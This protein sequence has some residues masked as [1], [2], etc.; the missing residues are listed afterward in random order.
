[1]PLENKLLYEF[2]RFRFDPADRLLSSDGVPVPLAPKAF[3]VLLVL[4][5]NGSRL[6]TKE[7]LMRKVWP[8]SFVEDANLT[9]N[10]SALRR[11]LGE[12]SDGHQY[13]E[14][15]P[16]NGYRFVMPVREVQENEPLRATGTGRPIQDTQLRF[17]PPVAEQRTSPPALAPAVTRRVEA[18]SVWFY[19]RV[20]VAGLLVAL[21]VWSYSVRRREATSSPP[22][23]SLR[24]LAVLPFHN[25]RENTQDDF[26]GFS[27]ADA[28]ITKLGY[29]NTL[30]V[31][32]SY[33]VKKYRTA[34]IDIA[35]TATDLNVDTLLTGTFLHD[36]TDMRIACQLIDAKT[37]NILWK[38]AF[39]LTYD[40]LLAVHD[41]VAQ[42]IIKGL[43]LTLS[44]SELERLKPDGEVNP[45]AYEYYLRGV[46]LY[47]KSD[48]PMAIKML[49]KSADLAP[50][51]ALTW[52]NLGKTYNANASFEL[53]GG[54][55]Y[56]KA[57]AAF[58]KALALQPGLIDARIYMA[59]MFTDTGSVEK[60]VPLLREALIANPNH[61]EVHWEL[62][63]AYRFGGMLQESAAE[64]ERARQLDPGVKINSSTLNSY[65]YLG[66]F[67]KFLGS[68]P[69][70]DDVA[71]IAFYRG[72][73]EY[74]KNNLD[75]AAKE[76]DHAFELDPS[77]LQAQI[78]KVL[79]L[80][81]HGQASR[82]AKTLQAV[83][84]KISDRGVGDPEALYK[85][86]QAYASLGD[87]S[88]ALRVLKHSIDNGFFPYPYIVSDSLLASVHDEG[89]FPELA[90][91]ARRRHE[92][93]KTA[94]F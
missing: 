85:I 26:L 60:A 86:A 57:Q 63:Y 66:E 47:S 5:Q 3:E 59:N 93:F 2:G 41:N 90:E 55:Q 45:L 14:T 83:E 79:S 58:E 18:K 39:D 33:A 78:G 70:T 8:D 21:L 76:F 1:M 77:L 23:L 19:S 38:G 68:L 89:G 30:V 67:D 11:L 50:A 6:T 53:G 25:L 12:T 91:A 4:V 51:Y 22:G 69:K 75:Q 7:E 36:G 24:R 65:L 20:V 81:I 16:K 48:F 88:S 27:L 82:A 74:Y 15:V 80:R 52:A 62:G 37:Q 42:Q 94:L 9:V 17:S 32:P 35:K 92:A 28:V 44:P 87:K 61:A 13:I 46:D 34:D 72:F 71:L 40:R 43:S 84:R 10:I 31:R 54:E 64:C 73:G 49:E 56:R 29:V